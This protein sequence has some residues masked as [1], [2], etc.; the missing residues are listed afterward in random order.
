MKTTKKQL[1]EIQ[2]IEKK[3]SEVCDT[4]KTTEVTRN[5]EGVILNKKTGKPHFPE[6]LKSIELEKAKDGTIFNKETGE[7]YR[8]LD[9]LL[10]SILKEKQKK[11]RDIS[12]N[13]SF[14]ETSP[15]L[16]LQLKKQGFKLPKG[17]LDSSE[18]IRYDLH[19]LS[20]IGVL[21]EKQLIKCFKKL[22]KKIS[23]KVVD[24]IIK[25]GEVAVHKKTILNQ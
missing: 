23:K 8:D 6:L 19:S 20:K 21:N 15:T 22:S 18:Q 13:L 14:G 12:V 25:E 5:D 7:P 9:S 24:S 17:Y 4:K 16:K 10:N 2:A 11:S 3:V 1:K